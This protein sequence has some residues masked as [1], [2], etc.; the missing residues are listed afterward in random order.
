M[1]LNYEVINNPIRN[2]IEQRRINK[3]NWRCRRI[4]FQVIIAFEEVDAVK[5]S[6]YNGNPKYTS[7][8]IRISS[9]HPGKGKDQIPASFVIS[10]PL[11][12][13]ARLISLEVL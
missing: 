12:I 5:V 9:D 11:K 4:N 2:S 8:N 1:L 10:A 7:G 13:L 6:F 3:Y